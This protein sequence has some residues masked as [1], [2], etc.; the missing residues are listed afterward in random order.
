LPVYPF[1][2][3]DTAGLCKIRGLRP[4]QKYLANPVGACLRTLLFSKQEVA[5]KRS[6]RHDII[7]YPAFHVTVAFAISA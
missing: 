3:D 2:Q 5:R 1:K 4:A 7:L 6:G